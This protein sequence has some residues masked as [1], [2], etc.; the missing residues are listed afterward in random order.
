MITS[1]VEKSEQNEVI[2]NDS[3][4][5][6]KEDKKFTDMKTSKEALV[7]GRE[8][9]KGQEVWRFNTLISFFYPDCSKLKIE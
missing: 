5:T 2:L 8:W 6:R 7:N 3:N 4:S 9:E 1:A